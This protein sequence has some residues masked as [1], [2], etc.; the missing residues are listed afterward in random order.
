MKKI[1]MVAIAMVLSACSTHFSTTTQVDDKAYL[2]L[3]GNINGAT[4]IID[5]QPDI[6]LDSSN[7]R[8]YT[9]GDETVVKFAV[10]VGNHLVE[11]TKA[12]KV[13][14][15]RKIYV[16]NGNSFEVRVP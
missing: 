5:E 15:K 13:L 3:T 14:V 12:G 16:T 8:R 9:E 4:L 1:L 6:N 11:I 7:I 2:L 10:N